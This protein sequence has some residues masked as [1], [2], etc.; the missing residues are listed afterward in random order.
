MILAVLAV[1][2]GCARPV[3]VEPPGPPPRPLEA[4]APAQDASLE[5]ADGVLVCPADKR[6]TFFVGT[7]EECETIRFDCPPTTHL[8]EGD[9]G[10]GCDVDEPAPY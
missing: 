7:P 1:V 9:C 4:A 2:A 6:P 10:C 3:D 5:R 8:V